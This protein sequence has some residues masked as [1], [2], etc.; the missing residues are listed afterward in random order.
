M[1]EAVKPYHHG[2]LRTALIE[3]GLAALEQNGSG[4]ISLRAIAREVGVSANAAYRHFANKDALLGALAAEGFRRFAARQAEAAQA[5]AGTHEMRAATGKA[6][7]AFAQAHPALFRL[8]FSRL[9]YLSESEDLKQAASAAFQALLQSSAQ[10]AQAPVGSER[11]LMMAL[12]NWSMVHGLSHLLLDG[13]L[14][15]F[16]M[17]AEQLL[18]GMIG[19]QDAQRPA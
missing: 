15:L 16:G 11:A 4:E 7:V 6:Y 8:M 2:N 13:Q 3:A 19:L 12:S 18:D 9:L 5:C 1:T 14:A 10:Q 17:S